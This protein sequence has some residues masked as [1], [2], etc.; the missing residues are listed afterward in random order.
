MKKVKSDFPCLRFLIRRFLFLE[1]S[2]QVLVVCDNKKIYTFDPE[3]REF[4]ESQILEGH[5]DI[6]VQI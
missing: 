2:K 6:I 3:K 5:K 4:V 1:K